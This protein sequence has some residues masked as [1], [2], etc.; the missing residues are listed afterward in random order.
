M[1]TSPHE[2]LLGLRWPEKFSQIPKEIFYRDDV[3]QRELQRIFYGAEWH[4]IAHVAEIASPGDYKTIW[5]GAASVLVLH[6]ADGRIRV[7]ENSCPHRGTQ[8]QTCAAGSLQRVEC[9]YHRWQFD[10]NGQL[11]GAPGSDRFPADFRKEDYGLRAL[12][13]EVVH[14]LVFATF[15]SDTV[16]VAEYLDEAPGYLEKAFG[17]APLMLLGYQKTLFDANWKV[18]AE[19]EGYHAPLLHRAFRILGW[20]GGTGVQSVS[21]HGHKL[22]AADLRLPTSD[23]LKDGSLIEFRDRKNPPR[24]YVINLFPMVAII[25]HLDVINVRFAF[26]R[27]PL[28]TEVHYAY[29]A[30]LEDDVE[31]IRHR[32]RQ[33]SNLIG[34][35]GMVSLEDGAVFNRVQRASGTASNAEFQKGVNGEIYAPCTIEQN[36]EAANLARWEHYREIMGFART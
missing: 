7:F 30:S 5:I 33:S 27:G 25:K 31:M 20:Q 35:S 23:F 26:P 18:Y 8:L 1:L 4:P 11:L 13:S 19:N 32:V 10:L 22:I 3:Y 28:Q 29:F 15:S 12:R 21:E 17:A 36:D 14:G 34:P 24:S 2:S 9:P 6:G 16:P